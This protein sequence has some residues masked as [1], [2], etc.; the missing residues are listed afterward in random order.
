MNPLAREAFRR[1]RR[2]ARL[3]LQLTAIGFVLQVVLGPALGPASKAELAAQIGGESKRAEI[4]PGV[5]ANLHPEH[6]LILEVLPQPRE[7]LLSLTERHC[8]SRDRVDLVRQAN[9]G[10]EQ[11]L[12]GVRY[13]I[14]A[15]CLEESQRRAALAAIFPADTI[16]SEGWRHQVGLPDAGG[17]VETLWRVAEWFTGNGQNYRVLREANG[18]RDE[19]VEVGQ[20]VLVPRELLRPVF[21]QLLPAATAAAR[22]T[23]TTSHAAQEPAPSTRAVLPI[24]TASGD[25]GYGEDAQGQYALYRLRPGEA[26]YSAVVVRFTG[27]LFAADV[28]PLA[29]DI[30]RR[31]GIDDVTDIPVGFGVKIPFDLLSP[32]FLP[33]DHPRRREYEE[34]LQASARFAARTTARH[35]EGVVV[36]L[37]AGH[38]GRDVGA[39]T[40]GVWESLYVYDIML[41]TKRLLEQRTGAT[42]YTTTRD[43]SGY[44]IP[45]RDVLPFS[46]GHRVLTDPPYSIEEA[47]I[48]TNLRWYLSN[49]IYERAKQAGIDSQKVVYLSIHAD[50]L[51][52]SVRGAMVY[53]PGLLPIPTSYGKSGTVYASRREVRE[54]PRV[55]FSKQERVRSEGMSRDL[56]EEIIRGFRSEGI[57]IHPNKPVRDR[58]VRRGGRPWVP[59]VLR[60][61]HVPV[62]VL[63]EVCNL[64]NPED[65]R[66]VQTRAFRQ[67]VAQGLVRGLLEYYGS[68]EADAGQRVAA[69]R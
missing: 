68:D 42:V 4:E 69:S 51:H 22:V 60:Y 16:E 36:I 9:G 8:G 1:P 49:S 63:V 56:A 34:G 66:L 61:N 53:V 13:R 10:V 57:A 46:R 58:I 5:V 43:G 48:G 11:L 31:S 65:L 40:G 27:R 19:S 64:V 62:K 52:P 47:H 7:G 39:S 32:E 14:P 35:L 54:S 55:S 33:S 30:A 38:G 24:E 29:H 3:P 28:T 67:D 25:L 23:A 15:A 59:A 37:D 2:L 21:A 12:G 45:D 44:E 20:Q 17:R 26:L 18:L 41:R 50:S 6:G